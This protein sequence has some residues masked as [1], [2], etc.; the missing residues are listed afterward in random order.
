MVRLP[1]VQWGG[2]N[3]DDGLANAR[4]ADVTGD[5]ILDPVVVQDGAKSPSR[6]TSRILDFSRLS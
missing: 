6:P 5:G 3:L 4:I 1:M 2:W